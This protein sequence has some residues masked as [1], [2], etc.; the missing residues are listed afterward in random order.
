LWRMLTVYTHRNPKVSKPKIFGNDIPVYTERKT[1][2][3]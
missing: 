2:G 1:F 3:D